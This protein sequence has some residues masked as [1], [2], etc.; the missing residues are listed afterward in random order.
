MSIFGI[1]AGHFVR[2]K[3]VTL[4]CIDSFVFHGVETIKAAVKAAMVDC[5]DSGATCYL[6]GLLR[7][8][9]QGSC[10]PSWISIYVVYHL[11]YARDC[12]DVGFVFFGLERDGD[13]EGPRFWRHGSFSGFAGK[14]GR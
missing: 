5:I 8:A 10:E 14:Q 13:T 2:R 7:S 4:D 9:F 12:N 6:A 11:S 1:R 3:E